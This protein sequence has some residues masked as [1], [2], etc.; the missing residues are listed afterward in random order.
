MLGGG[1]VFG[2]GGVLGGGGVCGGAGVFGGGGVFGVG[3]VFGNGVGFVPTGR[4]V[5]KFIKIPRPSGTKR[6]KH[7]VHEM[8]DNGS[9]E[10]S[11][12]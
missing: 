12:T 7:I 6:E 2:G 9:K 3:G 8:F 10:N 5:W 4:F 1:G 11:L